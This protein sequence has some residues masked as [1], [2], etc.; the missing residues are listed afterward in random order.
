VNTALRVYI[1]IC[2][3][4]LS[5]VLFASDACS[6][7]SIVTF[8]DVAVS[9]GSSFTTQSFFQ[10]GKSAATRHISDK[11]QTVVVEGPF[12]WVRIG[13]SPKMG[14]NFEK[15]F[16]LGHQF[17][18]FL[19]YF[20]EIVSNPR[21]S[22][23]VLFEGREYRARSGDYPYGGVAHLIPTTPGDRALGLIFEFPESKPIEVAFSDWRSFGHIEVPFQAKLYDGERVFSYRYTNI[24]MTP[25]TPLWFFEAVSAPSLDEIQ[26]YRLHRQLLAAHCLGDFDMIARLS[27]AQILAANN[28]ALQLVTNASVRDRFTELFERFDYTAYYDIAMPIIE[29]SEGSDLGWVGASVRAVGKQVM[30]GPPFDNQW[31]WL[32]IVKKEDGRWLHAGN[33]SNLA[34]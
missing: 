17:H 3:L 6:T 9:D 18:A 13:D 4:I 19:L 27:S 22:E 24:D 5:Q 23:Q 16:A 25:K 20:D 7:R 12:G 2:L 1:C 29:I 30:E 15:S 32:M 8:A 21:D 33:A 11:D 26:V 28:G 34:P 10:S 31:A 14:S